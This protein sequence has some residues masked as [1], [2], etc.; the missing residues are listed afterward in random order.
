[1]STNWMIREDQLDTD[2]QDFINNRVR[3]TG[4]IWVQGFAGSGKSVLLIHSILTVMRR[5][6][7]ATMCVV[8][9]THSLIDMFKTGMKELKFTKKI[10]V[11]T[12]FEFDKKSDNYDYIFC[13]EVQDLP[14]NIVRKLKDKSKKVIVAGDSN[15][16]IYENRVEPEE[17]KTI[18]TAEPFSLNV[19]HR[20]SR[21]IINI[22]QTMFPNMNI[23][24]AKRDNTKIDVEV[25]YCTTNSKMKE[26]EFVWKTAT[27]AVRVNDT[28]VILLPTHKKINSFLYLLNS[29][30]KKPQWTTVYNRYGDPKYDDLNQHLQENG[31]KLE[32]VGNSYGSF[33][34][35]VLNKNV[36]LM[37]YHSAKGMDFENV[38]IPFVN[39]ELGLHSD[40]DETV[41]MVAL[42]RSRKNLYIS[43]TDSP[44]YLVNKIKGNC[45]PVDID[46]ELTPA[47]PQGT[48]F[49]F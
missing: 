11:M 19:I 42:T 14:T 25:R 44:H 21:S 43:H 47:R 39:T 2:Q 24:K 32:Y 13:D 40:K 18:L 12:Y 8:V 36:I 5:E 49:G 31:V 16:S 29:H 23:W 41:F 4:N 1:M 28:A 10:P 30:L 48:S 46:N 15:Q 6:P 3:N 37:T 38:F 20:L 33:E 26:I 27:D 35:A 22:V 34:N 9:Y 45:R 17:I 7:N